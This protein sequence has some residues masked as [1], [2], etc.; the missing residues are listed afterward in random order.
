MV[1]YLVNGKAWRLYKT[2]SYPSETGPGIN[3]TILSLFLVTGHWSWLYTGGGN[4]YTESLEWKYCNTLCLLQHKMEIACLY[5]AMSFS[6][7]LGSCMQ[8]YHSPC[9]VCKQHDLFHVGKIL[10]PL[11]SKGILWLV[12]IGLAFTCIC[13]YI[14]PTNNILENH[15]TCSEIDL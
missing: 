14:A 2:F 7:S 1:Y 11:K 12:L 4:R 15:N 8:C 6:V 3:K 13:I 10:A 9:A 5:N